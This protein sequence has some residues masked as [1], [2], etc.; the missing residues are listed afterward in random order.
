LVHEGYFR[1]QH[2]I[3]SVLCHFCAPDIHD[4]HPVNFPCEWRIELLHDFSR[5]DIVNTYNN[6]V[7]LHEIIYGSAFL[8]K[9]GVGNHIELNVDPTAGQFFTDSLPDFICRADRDSGLVD[10]DL[11]VFH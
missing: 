6:A 1:C 3:C 8:E 2:G 5:S 10:D 9:F 7:R 4:D 11:E